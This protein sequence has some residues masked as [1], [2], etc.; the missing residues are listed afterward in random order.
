MSRVGL[1][2]AWETRRDEASQRLVLASVSRQLELQVFEAG[3]CGK[4]R[5]CLKKHHKLVLAQVRRAAEKELKDP[6]R[7]LASSLRSG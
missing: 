5:F 3:L 4:L 7:L 6:P 1:V 2:S